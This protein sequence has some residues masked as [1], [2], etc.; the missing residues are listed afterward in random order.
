M[1]LTRQ[2]VQ[3]LVNEMASDGLVRFGTNP[4]HQKAK[5]VLLTARGAAAYEAAMERQRP[6]AGKLADGLTAK[7][8]ET[9]AAMLRL[10]RRRIEARSGRG[11]RSGLD[12]TGDALRDG[13]GM[14]AG[15]HNSAL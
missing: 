4:H 13:R 3:R 14:E 12:K 2:A 15:S 8:I 10:I 7:Q 1:G 6:W 11:T 9:A 5:L